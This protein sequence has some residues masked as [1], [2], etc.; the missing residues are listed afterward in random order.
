MVLRHVGPGKR[1]PALG[2]LDRDHGMGRITLVHGQMV[3]FHFHGKQATVFYK[4]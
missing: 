1:R 4:D 2:R 3:K